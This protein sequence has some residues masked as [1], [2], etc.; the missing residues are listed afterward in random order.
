M[1]FNKAAL[2]NLV[3]LWKFFLGEMNFLTFLKEGVLVVSTLIYSFLS[4]ITGCVRE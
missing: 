1:L 2:Y 4:K 3:M